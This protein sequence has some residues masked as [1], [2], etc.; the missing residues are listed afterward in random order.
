[1]LKRIQE[2]GESQNLLMSKA[3]QLLLKWA[4]EDI[5]I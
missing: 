4:K 1:M 3:N 2:T 5:K